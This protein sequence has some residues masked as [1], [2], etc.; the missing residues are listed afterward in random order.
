M[1]FYL[2]EDSSNIS[3]HSFKVNISP[4]FSPT[5]Q[6]RYTV[7]ICSNKLC[8][9]RIILLQYKLPYFLNI[10]INMMSQCISEVQFITSTNI[11]FWLMLATILS[12]F[13]Y[14]VLGHYPVS[15]NNGMHLKLQYYFNC[16]KKVTVKSY[17]PERVKG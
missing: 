6:L 4:I 1:L 12:I 8:D 5:L 3:H 10:T 13:S 15:K 11:T 7:Y 2:D 16:Y 9:T 17:C 14:I